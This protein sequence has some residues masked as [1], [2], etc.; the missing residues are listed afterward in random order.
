MK[1]GE[2]V[3]WPANVPGASAEKFM[4]NPNKGCK[5]A[6][7]GHL[8]GRVE[9]PPIERSGEP[10]RKWE[11][12]L[13]RT[14]HPCRAIGKDSQRVLWVPSYSNVL[15]PATFKLHFELDELLEDPHYCWEVQIRPKEKVRISPGL[16]MWTY[17]IGVNTK[18]KLPKLFRPPYARRT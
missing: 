7:Q 6:L 14:T 16:F 8:I 12:F 18:S 13:V 3:A 11:C 10:P 9:M 4:F 1:T 17:L 2:L 5:G 15:I